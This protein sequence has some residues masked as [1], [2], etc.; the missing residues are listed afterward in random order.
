M[1]FRFR[2]C[3][4]ATSHP[5]ATASKQYPSTSRRNA[6]SYKD[7]PVVIV[8]LQSSRE[9]ER[10]HRTIRVVVGGDQVNDR[11]VAQDERSPTGDESANGQ[12]LVLTDVLRRK[13][14]NRSQGLTPIPGRRA[15]AAVL[16]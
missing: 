9:P 8:F 16:L 1:V 11:S 13:D 2:R 12:Q 7:S 10:L 5:L 14:A 6:S 15:P 3:S 4:F